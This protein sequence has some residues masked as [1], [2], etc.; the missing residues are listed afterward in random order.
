VQR[1]NAPLT[2]EDRLFARRIGR[3]LLTAY[4]SAA[5]ALSAGVMA[6]LVLKNSTTVNATVEPSARTSALGQH[7]EPVRLMRGGPSW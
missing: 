1:F 5:L 6:H 2:A 7:S 4:T 3:V